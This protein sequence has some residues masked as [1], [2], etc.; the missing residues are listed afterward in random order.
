[1]LY[2]NKN[3]AGKFSNMVIGMAELVDGIIRVMSFGFVM[4]RF[5]LN[6]SSWQTKK[7]LTK[8]KKILYKGLNFKNICV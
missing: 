4:T 1:M 7:Y 3:P 2:I 5:P 6:A 8:L